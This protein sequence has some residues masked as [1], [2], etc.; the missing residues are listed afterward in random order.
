MKTVNRM[1][2]IWTTTLWLMTTVMAQNVSTLSLSDLP[3]PLPPSQAFQWSVERNGDAQAT[4]VVQIAEGY[5]VYRDKLVVKGEGVSIAYLPSGKVKSD[6]A[7]GD[8]SIWTSRVEVPIALAETAQA[9][10][11]T[12]QGCQDGGVCYPKQ[13]L[14]LTLPSTSVTNAGN[15]LFGNR[16]SNA[17]AQNASILNLGDKDDLLPEAEAFAPQMS[18]GEDGIVNV[19]WHVADGYYLYTD[20][21][22]VSPNDAV[23]NVFKSQG[24]THKDDFFGEQT[25]YRQQNG[26]VKIYLNERAKDSITLTYQGCAD[27]GVCY[28]VMERVFPLPANFTA[29]LASTVEVSSTNTISEKSRIERALAGNLFVAIGLLLLAGIALAFTPCVLPMLPILLG[30][31]SSQANLSRERT[32]VLAGAYALGMAFMT[33]MFGVIV[34]LLGINLQIIFQKWWLLLLFAT[35][36]ALAGVAMLGVFDINVP[37]KVQN[38]VNKWQS[39]FST[40]K[41][42][43]TFIVGA[44]SVLVVGPC[45]APPLFAVLTYASTTGDVVKSGVY[46]FALGLGMG[47]P[48]VVFAVYSNKAPKTGQWSILIKQVMGW[49]L[50]AVALW[51]LSR[52]VSGQVSLMLWGVWS[53]AV[54]YTIFKIVLPKLKMAKAIVAGL[55]AIIGLIWII[56]GATGGANP[57]SPFKVT[58]KIGYVYANSIAELN[59][60]ISEHDVLLLDIYADWC[61]SCKKNEALVFTQPEV[62][63]RLNEIVVVKVDMTET[64]QSHRE[65]L[66]SLKLVGPPALIVYKKGIK[67]EQMIGE[68]EKNQ[69]LTA[70][71]PNG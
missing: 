37:F 24:D 52:L 51:L 25:V 45:V 56:G 55:L 11:L 30:M 14:T 65:L 60:R 27:V 7:F 50:I 22:N 15:P 29:N 49:L 40:G 66:A 21:I 8:V 5:Y 36:F 53:I 23:T 71:K 28:P 61:I 46:L 13:K 18:L 16:S 44:L 63:R 20:R 42:L 9:V 33:A 1:L 6:P 57:F 54:A 35:A 43:S 10:A 31:L 12:Y 3:K 48:L 47:L 70:L 19:T 69:L 41:P 59:Q 68:V 67:T 2:A 38:Q 58:P 39:K 17:L 32:I 4:L 34:S 64:V 26:Q 62:F